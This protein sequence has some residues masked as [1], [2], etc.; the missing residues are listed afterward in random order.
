LTRTV[1][2]LLVLAGLPTG[3]FQHLGAA[4]LLYFGAP[5]Q[6]SIILIEARKPVA[7]DQA[8]VDSEEA[9]ADGG[10]PPAATPAREAA[11]APVAVAAP[12]RRAPRRMASARILLPRST[13][14]PAG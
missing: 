13:G 14:P 11:G 12:E 3:A 2:I 6:G 5:D 8:S 7:R 4:H 10:E 9:L 1:A